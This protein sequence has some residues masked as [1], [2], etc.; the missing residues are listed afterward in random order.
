MATEERLASPTE[1]P[2][3]GV[4]DAMP[5]TTLAPSAVPSRGR[6]HEVIEAENDE[7]LCRAARG[8]DDRWYPDDD[9][10]AFMPSAVPD[11]Q[12]VSISGSQMGIAFLVQRVDA[13]HVRFVHTLPTTSDGTREYQSLLWH[14]RIARK[15]IG[16]RE[17]VVLTFDEDVSSYD[18]P[19]DDDCHDVHERHIGHCVIC[20][21]DEAGALACPHDLVVRESATHTRY[22]DAN[23]DRTPHHVVS[24]HDHRFATNID[25]LGYISIAPTTRKHPHVDDLCHLPRSAAIKI[26]G[27]IGVSGEEPVGHT[28]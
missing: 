4:R 13:G 19:V 14:E 15:S 3:A 25:D 27:G 12:L 28:E 16:Q 18:C 2:D 20:E 22:E 1:A 8:I 5:P 6:L 11:L 17:L 7:A 9:R 23:D 26:R 24:H 21:R 10:C